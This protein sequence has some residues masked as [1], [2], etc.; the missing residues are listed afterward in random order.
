MEGCFS[1][2]LTRLF[3]G[4]FIE[5]H[6]NSSSTWNT[7]TNLTNICD[8]PTGKTYLI[9]HR[10][11]DITMS[12]TVLTLTVSTVLRFSTSGYSGLVHLHLTKTVVWERMVNTQLLSIMFFAVMLD[13]FSEASPPSVHPLARTCHETRLRGKT[14]RVAPCNIF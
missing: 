12:V 2:I 14:S 5:C 8:L 11:R 6:L 7:F 4:G 3:W 9:Q 13:W 1:R 10:D